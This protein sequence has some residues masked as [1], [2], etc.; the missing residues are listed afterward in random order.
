M[1]GWTVVLG[2]A[3][4]WHISEHKESLDVTYLAHA[5]AYIEKD[6]AYRRWNALQ[7]GVYA[8]ISEHTSPNPHLKLAH[9]EVTTESGTQLT[10]IN[11]AYMSRQVNEL[12]A[13]DKG[14]LGRITSLKPIRPENKADAWES[15]AL[16]AFESGETEVNGLGDING[17]RYLRLMRP[18]VTEKACLKCHEFQGYKVGDIRGGI[19]VSIPYGP[20]AAQKQRYLQEIILTNGGI[21][22]IGILGIYLGSQVARRRSWQK[23]QVEEQLRSV[24]LAAPVGVGVVKSRVIK[25]VNKQMCEITGYRASELVDQD[26]RMLYPSDEDYE[27][28]GREKYAQIKTEGIGTV[29]TRWRR[30]DGQIIDVLLSSAPLDKNDLSK[31]LTFTA[32]NITERKRVEADLIESKEVYRGVVQDTPVLLCR[33]LPDGEIV[34]V[35]NAY[36][37]YFQMQPEALVGSKFLDLI[38]E[39]DRQMVMANLAGLSE[40]TPTQS[41]EHQVIAP[42]G[43]VRWQRWTNRAIFNALGKVMVYQSIGEDITERKQ[44]EERLHQAAAVFASTV[45]GVTITN[46]E[47]RILDVNQAFSDITGYERDE[48]IGENPRILKSGRHDINFYQAMWQSLLSTGQWRGEIWNRRKDGHV[49][50]ELLT[51]SIVRDQNGSSTGY[52]GVFSDITNIKQSEERLDYLAHHDALTDL[53]NRLLLNARLHQSIKHSSRQHAMMAVVFIDLDRFKHLN[54]SLGHPLGD[55]LLRQLAKRLD[56]TIRSDDTVARISGDEFVV[57][58]ED[59]GTAEHT[60]VAVDKLMEVFKTP[61]LLEMNKVYITAS[62]GVSLYPQDGDQATELLQ[63][64]DAAMHRAK[65]EGRNTYQFYTSDLTSAAFEHV[66]LENALRGALANQEFRLVYQPRVDLMSG[67]FTG[68]EALLRWHHPNQGVIS[69][70]RFI[71]IAEQGGLII[72]IGAWVLS[73]ACAQGKAWLDQGYD[74]GRIAVN[75]A[76]P[77]IQDPGFIQQVESILKASGFPTGHLELEVTESFVM[78]RTEDCIQQLTTLRAL[79]IEIAIDDF[80]T[81]YSSLSYLK[82]LPIDNLKIDQSFVRD[83]PND[84][85]DMAISEAVIAMGKALGMRII[86]EGVETEKQA[87]FLREKGCA[88]AQGYLFSRPVSAEKLEERLRG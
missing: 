38:P 46:L 37:E 70:A 57:L 40:N 18:L 80:G 30:K 14:V 21:W 27:F 73:T 51:I 74:I 88:Q 64:A 28:V 31:G 67:K 85:N 10:L 61:F 81:G 44:D 48:V 84:P 9:R 76:G 68:M 86:A 72:D 82:Q 39:A 15:K 32:M 49:Y 17:E 25:D 16:K 47:G 5:R 12:M 65:D 83:I 50:P 29:E 11:P 23:T 26:A 75:V 34:F 33:F 62:M 24:F 13:L 78:R 1:I 56:Q 4:V 41:H 54:D 22:G 55:D 59:V 69:P 7:G 42:D 71:P 87:E 36:A 6:V 58:L 2:I 20:I 60:A 66:F 77:Q 3:A 19:S 45:E 53:P 43:T 63:H 8:P 79:G 52:V 35:N